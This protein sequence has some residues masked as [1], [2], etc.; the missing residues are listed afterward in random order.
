MA[1]IELWHVG[2]VG[3][4]ALI[5][6]HLY[7]SPYTKVEESFNIQATHDILKYGVP[8]S[9]V[10]L[11]LKAQYDHMTFAGAVPRTFIGPLILAAI[12]KPFIW[13]GQLDGLQ[14]QLLV[15]GVLGLLNGAALISYASG[16]RQAYGITA[17]NWYTALQASQFHLTYYSSRT[18]P[19]MFAFGITTIVFRSELAL[20]LASQCLYLLAKSANLSSA[21]S[22]VRTVFLPAILSATIAGLLLTVSIDTF[23][24]QSRTLLWPELVAFLSNI[25]PSNDSLGASA[26]G[27]SPWHWYFTSALPRLLLNPALLLLIPWGLT[28]T[29]LRP[30]IIDL[31]LPSL[32]YVGVYSILPHKE[33]RFIFP[34]V[35]PVTAAVAVC[36]AYISNRVE[37]SVLYKFSHYILILST[38][39]TTIFATGVLLPLSALTHPGGQAL[40]AL[41]AL[42]VNYAPQPQIRV[43]L[44]NLA[45][46]TGVTHFLDEPLSDIRERPVFTLPGSPD[47]RKA[48]IR[49][50][51]PARW[52]YDKT[53]NETEFLTPTFWS[54]FDYVIVE[55]PSRVI[56][57]W[58]VVDKVPGLGRPKVLQPDVGRGL[59]VLGSKQERREDDGLSRLTQAMYG[60][61]CKWVYGVVHDVLR[62]GFGTDKLLGKSWSWTKGWWVQWG[63]ETKLYI[64]K[65]AESGISP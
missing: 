33:T 3:I 30:A 21:I 7:L 35:P 60:P 53:D 38:I 51:R 12:A 27:I 8:T 56:G 18:L 24:W 41:H 20:L 26:W 2:S 55:D 42:S 54:Q 48:T 32:S 52:L 15:R 65:R 58:D 57:A 13:Y 62:E 50:T 36:A 22:L 59:L 28:A 9:N 23:F 64:L 45:L 29:T 5:F 61:V 47:G 46:Q 44:T 34:V 4:L 14:Q 10:Y 1:R 6:L 31:I 16:V 19:N 17:A 25:F 37:R 40:D 43:H 39:M 11:K 63:L 49:S